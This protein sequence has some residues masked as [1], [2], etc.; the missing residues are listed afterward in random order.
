MKSK[1][2]STTQ[3]GNHINPRSH[4]FDKNFVKPTKEL[5]SQNIFTFFISFEIN[6]VVK[7]LNLLSLVYVKSILAK[8]G[9]SKT[10]TFDNFRGSE[11]LL[12]YFLALTKSKNVFEPNLEVLKL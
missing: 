7:D 10:A 11:I 9:V 2:V 4:F 8:F 1:A 3:C 6:F 5:I 12:Y